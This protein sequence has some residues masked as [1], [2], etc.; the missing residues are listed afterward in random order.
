MHP[1]V[2]TWVAA[3]LTRW[4]PRQAILDLGGRDINGSCRDLFPAVARYCSV[5]LLPG[6]GVDVVAD[7]TRYTPPWAPDCVLCLEV[8][9]HSRKPA[10]F[11][12]HAHRLLRPDGLLLITCA[13][14][15]RKPHSAGDGGPLQDGEYYRNV[16][17][18]ALYRWLRG[19]T[20]GAEVY[21]ERGDLYAWAVR[22]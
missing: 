22:P 9:E 16:E 8:L 6:G 5:D 3:Q 17:P 1:E 19:W 21:P 13:M 20:W 18:Q 15:P 10:A 14:E 11:I 2:R 12:R 7:A 4:P